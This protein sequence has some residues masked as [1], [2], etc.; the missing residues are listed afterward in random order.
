MQNPH[1]LPPALERAST[2]KCGSHGAGQWCRELW[3]NGEGEDYNWGF[4][5]YRTIYTPE[6]DR[7][8]LQAHW[9]FASALPWHKNGEP[10]LT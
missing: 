2:I 8:R 10:A 4:R 7:G 9:T 3:T 5:I 6:S 1:P